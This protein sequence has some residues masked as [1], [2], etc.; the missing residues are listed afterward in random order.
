MALCRKKAVLPRRQK[1]SNVVGLVLSVVLFYRAAVEP[2]F[3]KCNLQ[4]M[5]HNLFSLPAEL[6]AHELFEPL[7]TGNGIVIERIIS[8]G[9]TT[10][11]GEWYDQTRDEWVVLLQGRAVLLFADA[12]EVEL[13][14]GDWLLI[15]AHKKHR[16]VFTSSEPPC[17]WLAVH[18]QLT[19]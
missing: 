18:A 9:Q 10:P 3:V 11:E 7:A 12:S 13:Q 6:P 16:V 1:N 5:L 4:N 17:V 14:P 8:T 19:L 2:Q 15:P